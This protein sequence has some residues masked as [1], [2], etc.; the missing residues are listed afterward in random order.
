MALQTV[1]QLAKSSGVSVAMIYV[2]VHERRFPVHRV[3][4]VG[5][6]GRILIDGD[7]FGKFV[8]AQQVEAVPMVDQPMRGDRTDETGRLEPKD[9][10]NMGHRASHVSGGVQVV[11]ENGP[12]GW[13]SYAITGLTF[14]QLH[15]LRETLEETRG[16]GLAVEMVK[17]ICTF[18]ELKRVVD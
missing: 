8:E 2:W 15:Q 4:G 11:R 16:C 12:L 17:M 6:R 1:K 14:G 5:R 18:P 3:G 9:M 10:R 7:V 13:P